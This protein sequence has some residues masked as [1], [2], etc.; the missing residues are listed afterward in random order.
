MD[1]RITKTPP[2]EASEEVRAAWIGLVLPLA[3]PGARML[4]SVGVL[5]RPKTQLGLFFA[6][7]FGKTKRETG[8]LVEASRAVEIL[9]RHAPDAAKWW[10]HNAT[11]SIKPGQY[12]V[13][14][15]DVC[16]EV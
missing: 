8:Y 6:R 1:I 11:L 16:E 10:H 7:F 2:G 14:A 4:E 3:I 9:T 12:F 13:F 5:S 15:A